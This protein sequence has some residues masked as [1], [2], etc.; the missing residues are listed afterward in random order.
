MRISDWSSDVCSSDLFALSP[1]LYM[2]FMEPL[3][4][5]DGSVEASWDHLAQR[6]RPDLVA[7]TRALAPP[8]LRW[9]GLLSAYYRWREGV[10]PRSART[11]M[12]N[13]MWGGVETS[14]IGTDE[15]LDFCGLIGAEPLMCVNFASEGDPKWAVN[16]L[17]EHRAG[18]A[19]D[20]KST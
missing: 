7:A 8:M 10:G 14:Q 18:D 3:G 16:A 19:Q 1:Y 12:H 11:P 15:F 17:G 6:W 13:L 5:T 2:Q 9:G 4:T 20:R